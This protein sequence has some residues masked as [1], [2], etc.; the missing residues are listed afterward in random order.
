MPEELEP[1][2][3]PD[4]LLYLWEWFYELSNGRQ[5]GEFGPMP[6]SFTEIKAWA[7]LSKAEPDAWEVKVIK[8]LDRLFLTEALKK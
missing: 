6:L 7:D 5:Y 4:A 3:R 1:Q 8:Q 2:G